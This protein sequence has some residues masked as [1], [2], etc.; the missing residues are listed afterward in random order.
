MN[1]GDEEILLIVLL[2]KCVRI[3]PFRNNDTQ[4]QRK[5][6]KKVMKKKQKIDREA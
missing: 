2:G 4:K 5:K 1:K 6:D 3:I